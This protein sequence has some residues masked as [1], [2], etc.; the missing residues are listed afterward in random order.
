MTSK[1]FVIY[2]VNL[3]MK[4]GFKNR[5]HF[6]TAFKKEYGFPFFAT[7]SRIKKRDRIK[8]SLLVVVI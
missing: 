2:N 4:V 3:D 5:S 8:P 7:D 6:S 1:L